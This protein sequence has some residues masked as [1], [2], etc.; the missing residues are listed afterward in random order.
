MHLRDLGLPRPGRVVLFSPWL[1][2][3]LADPAARTL[4]KHDVM[5]DVDALQMHGRWWAG[6]EDA[7]QPLLSPLFGDPTHLPP[8]DI[9]QGTDDI[10]IADA[11]SFYRDAMK[12]G[13]DVRLYETLGGCHVF[14]L[15][16][17]MPEAKEVYRIV[18]RNLNQTPL[19]KKQ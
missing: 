9:F 4:E 7:R 15:F 3:T 18:G 10:F 1:N 2:L 13:A 14:M 12:A 5:L 8:V 19:V 17:F 16:P 11:R 6:G